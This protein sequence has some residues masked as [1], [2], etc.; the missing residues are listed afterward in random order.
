MFRCRG[1][2]SALLV[3]YILLTLVSVPM[4]D[5]AVWLVCKPFLSEP[6]SDETLLLLL[7]PAKAHG[8]TQS[9]SAQ[10]SSRGYGVKN[11]ATPF[12][13][14]FGN[15]TV[16]RAKGARK[17]RGSC[18]IGGRAPARQ[19]AMPSCPT[20]LQSP[21]FKPPN[22]RPIRPP[23]PLQALNLKPY[24]PKPPLAVSP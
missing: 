9:C 19:W 18:A 3:N 12:A 17:V 16:N 6:Y 14:C 15:V 22:P 1:L 24:N 20:L 21:T 4:Y 7:E 11:V 10:R 8:S 13:A 23:K 2:G 5:R